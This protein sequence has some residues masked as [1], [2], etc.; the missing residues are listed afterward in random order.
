[1]PKTSP[2]S[3]SSPTFLPGLEDMEGKV[4]ERIQAANSKLIVSGR[5]AIAQVPP[6]PPAAGTPD[7]RR[8]MGERLTKRFGALTA[9]NDVSLQIARRLVLFDPRAFGLRQDHAD[10]HDRRLRGA[11]IRRYSDQGQVR[12][13][14]AA[15]PAERQHGVPAS[16]ALS[17]DEGR[18]EHRLGLRRRGTW[19]EIAPRWPT[20]WPASGSPTGGK[21]I[22]QL[23]GGQKQRIAIARCMVLDPD[24]L[25]LD[26]PLGALDLSFASI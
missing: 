8:R 17:D 15:Q 2:T 16:R 13:R 7:A 24:V 20:Y 19:E 18:R 14:H 12:H 9:V 5:R 21:A 6:T 25:L 26:E 3:S 23:S 10:A 11:G 4:L 22:N 1:M